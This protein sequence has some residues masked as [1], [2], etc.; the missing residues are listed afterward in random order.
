[1]GIVNIVLHCR[2]LIQNTVAGSFISICLKGSPAS[3]WMT[4]LK[5]YP[6]N[7]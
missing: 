5:V 2:F 1:M 6:R 3:L 7:Y 4:V